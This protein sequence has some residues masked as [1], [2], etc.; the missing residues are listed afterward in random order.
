MFKNS[1]IDIIL[2]DRYFTIIR[3]YNNETYTIKYIDDIPE[4]NFDNYLRKNSGV[5]VLGS[6]YT[7]SE[8]AILVNESIFK[9]QNNIIKTLFYESIK[10]DIEKR[11]ICFN[12]NSFNFKIYSKEQFLNPYIPIMFFFLK[13]GHFGGNPQ[14]INNYKFYRYYNLFRNRSKIENLDTLLL[15]YFEV[16]YKNNLQN[17]KNA[18]LL[19][20]E[21][22]DVKNK[23]KNKLRDL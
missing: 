16:N 7:V 19:V 23:L 4:E 3:D 20:Q 18:L 14:N 6:I 21:T 8:T 2:D 10:I 5:D 13:Q 1:N 15:E 12:K 11:L 17:L 9:N 22:D